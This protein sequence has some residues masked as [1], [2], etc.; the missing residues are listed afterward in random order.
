MTAADKLARE[1][2]K[3]EKR[4][5]ITTIFADIRGFTSFSEKQSPE[6]LVAI[7]NRYLA[8]MAEAVAEAQD[9][10]FLGRGAMYPLALEGADLDAALIV[11]GDVGLVDVSDLARLGVQEVA[12]DLKLARDVEQFGFLVR[13]G[14]VKARI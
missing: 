4:T 12:V 8:A 2:A 10:L 7:L 13:H 5:P 3:L 9:V 11:G 14:V 1:D 6:K